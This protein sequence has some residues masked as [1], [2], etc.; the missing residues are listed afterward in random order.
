MGALWVPALPFPIS[1][2]TDVGFKIIKAWPCKSRRGEY[3]GK[4][5]THGPFLRSKLVGNEEKYGD[6]TGS[7][8]WH[9]W[10]GGVGGVTGQL[11]PLEA[12]Y[13]PSTY[14]DY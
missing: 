1:V 7:P 5:D 13:S 4:S 11:L 9:L 3:G 6:F 8:K 12:S 2:G 14:K 10:G